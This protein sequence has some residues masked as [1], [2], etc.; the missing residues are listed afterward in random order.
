[1]LKWIFVFEALLQWLRLTYLFLSILL[2][3]FIYNL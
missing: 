3:S 2:L 1:V